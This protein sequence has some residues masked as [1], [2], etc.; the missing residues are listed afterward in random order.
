[1]TGLVVGYL[2]IF[3]AICRGIKGTSKVVYLTALAPY[4]FLIFLLVKGLSLPGSALGIQYLFVPNWTPLFT[5][6]V[7]QDSIV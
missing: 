3:L 4:F 2:L 1:M 6:K 5:L 7:W